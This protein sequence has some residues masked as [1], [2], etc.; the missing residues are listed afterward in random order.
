MTENHTKHSLKS[1][2]TLVISANVFFVCSH[3]QIQ[4]AI[5]RRLKLRDICGPLELVELLKSYK[6]QKFKIFVLQMT[7][8]E[9]FNAYSVKSK[10]LVFSMYLWHVLNSC[11][12]KK[13]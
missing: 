8:P 12:I 1:D 11:S 9:D 6:S 2:T 10:K 5:D 4:S 7:P 13:K 3:S